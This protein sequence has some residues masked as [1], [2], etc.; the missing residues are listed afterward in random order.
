MDYEVPMLQPMYELPII[1]DLE[2]F[3]HGAAA[4][5]MGCCTGGIW[6]PEVPKK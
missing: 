3:V 6:C 4:E 5:V 1:I 2:E